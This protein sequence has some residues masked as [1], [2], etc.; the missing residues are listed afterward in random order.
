MKKTSIYG[1]DGAPF[2]IIFTDLDGTLL[3]HISYDWSKAKPALKICQS[4]HIPVIMVSSKTRAELD[5][6]RKEMAISFPLISENG[7]GI[8]FPK[9]LSDA[10]PP[11]A[12]LAENLFQWP[13]GVPYDQLVN[14]FLEIR[15]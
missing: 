1:R 7:G 5:I 14:S 6:L 8:F 4:L 15:E 10:V 12:F 2:V 13:M 9:E 11:G 3:D